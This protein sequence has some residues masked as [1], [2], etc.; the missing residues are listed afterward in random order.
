M[1]PSHRQAKKERLKNQIPN[2]SSQYTRIRG[3][4]PQ[5]D[6][7]YIQ[8]ITSN[9]IRSSEKLIAFPLG[10]RQGCPMPSFLFDIALNVLV[11][12]FLKSKKKQEKIVFNK[13]FY[14]IKMS[15]Y[16]HF[17]L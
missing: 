6:K 4:L 15:K 13:V 9:S 1:F 10:T 11:G 2:K 8:R 7:E 5:L 16:Y 12:T 3:K 14:L 17:N